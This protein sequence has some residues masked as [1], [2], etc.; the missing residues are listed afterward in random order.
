L[1]GVAFFNVV[2][3]TCI[4]SSKDN[5]DT[6]PEAVQVIHS[7]T[8]DFIAALAEQPTHKI[9]STF[10]EISH[11]LGEKRLV[12]ADHLLHMFSTPY[13]A[14]HADLVSLKALP[15]LLNLFVQFPHNNLLHAVVYQI[16]TQI[17][18]SAAGSP[19]KLHLF[20]EC[21][22][23]NQ[24]LQCVAKNDQAT[25]KD[26][27]KA[28]LGYMG[29][30]IAI[31]NGIQSIASQEV[32]AAAIKTASP[33]WKNYVDGALAQFNDEQQHDLGGPAPIQTRAEQQKQ[34]EQQQREQANQQDS[35]HQDDGFGET[36]FGV[37]DED[38]E[39]RE[40]KMRLAAS[41]GGF[42][43]DFG[44]SSANHSNTALEQ[45]NPPA[46]QPQQGFD[47]DFDA[48]FDDAPF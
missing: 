2:L 39:E 48:T 15:A 13:P 45:G 17:F 19:L 25:A 27:H 28:R 5:V 16:L 11:P 1:H 44:N 36:S 3:E 34:L 10:G 8:A 40:R 26:G 7:V 9:V 35:Q 12:A 21:D 22:I 29:H 37:D 46:E 6:V 41:F 23:L 20:T 43:D 42:D 24:V 4:A 31:S 32:V 38:E 30:I 18:K 47:T 14:V 33:A